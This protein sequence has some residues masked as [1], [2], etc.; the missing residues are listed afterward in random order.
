[1]EN[2][3]SQDEKI[4]ENA[5]LDAELRKLEKDIKAGDPDAINKALDISDRRCKLLGLYPPALP[6]SRLS[7]IA[8]SLLADLETQGAQPIDYNSLDDR[9]F[10]ILAGVPL[11][12]NLSTVSDE[13]VMRLAGVEDTDWNQ[14]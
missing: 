3:L 8:A 13:E 6:Q 10:R 12:L 7:G 5:R 9:T 1:M 2:E 11:D 4:I 14:D